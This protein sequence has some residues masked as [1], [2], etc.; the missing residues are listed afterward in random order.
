RPPVP[1]EP[2]PGGSRGVLE[3]GSPEA[4]GN[5]IKCIIQSTNQCTNFFSHRLQNPDDIDHF[6]RIIPKQA[7]RLLDQVTVLAA[8]EAILFGS[9]FHVPARA[10]VRLPSKEP[11]SSTAAP[12]VDWSKDTIF[13]LSEVV[14]SWGITTPDDQEQQADPQSDIDDEIPF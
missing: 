7:Q 14:E 3:A 5:G 4:P 9:A 10:Q 6:R 8:G 11:W 1:L 13:P 12:F 2:R